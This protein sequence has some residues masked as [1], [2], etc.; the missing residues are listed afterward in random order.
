MTMQVYTRE[1][2]LL[3]GSSFVAGVGTVLFVVMGGVLAE[4]VDFTGITLHG[5]V[6]VGLGLFVVALV[7]GA[8]ILTIAGA[9]GILVSTS[10]TT[11]ALIL[12]VRRRSQKA[13]PSS[14]ITS[15]RS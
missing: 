3:M 6:L 1:L 14:Q 9:A 15:R 4:S 11:P 12:T 8:S 13:S 2:V 5:V 7:E 10:L